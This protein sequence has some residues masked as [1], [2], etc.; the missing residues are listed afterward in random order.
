MYKPRV[1]S[2]IY[3]TDAYLGISR[4]LT[5]REQLMSVLELA[6]AEPINT[7]AEIGIGNVVTSSLL[8]NFGF[9][10]VTIDYN[11]KLNPDIVCSVTELRRKVK[12]QFDLVLCYEVLE[13]L[14][15]SDFGN[16]LQNIAAITRSYL[17]MSLPYAG[18]TFK[19]HLYLSKYGERQLNIIKRLPLFWKSH[20]VTGGHYWEPGKRGFSKRRIRR[21][22]TRYFDIQKEWLY[23]Y[24]NSQ[25]FYLCK[26]IVV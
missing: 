9:Y 20:V 18:L 4:F 21:N 5:Y 15:F 2:G 12:Q 23:A 3:F 8:R 11:P 19:V 22:I 17:I 16:A 7:I 1:D 10:P 14:K 6:R 24:N 13:H 26:K 25:I